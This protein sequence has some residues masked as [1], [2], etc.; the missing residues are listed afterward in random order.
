MNAVVRKKTVTSAE[1]LELK[2]RG[3]DCR[4]EFY[5]VT[6]ARLVFELDQIR[7]ENA[8]LRSRLDA[9]ERPFASLAARIRARFFEEAAS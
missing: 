4:P 2:Q 9:V 3:F 8:K 7:E 5:P 1:L 6:V